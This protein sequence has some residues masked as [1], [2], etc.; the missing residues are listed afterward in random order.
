MKPEARCCGSL[1]V[2]VSVEACGKEVVGNL[3]SL[4][5]AVDTFEN[6]EI[7]PSIVGFV[8]EVVF[9]DKFLGNIS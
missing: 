9:R 2:A 6:F 3:S 1:V 7:D 4:E 8:S 5:K